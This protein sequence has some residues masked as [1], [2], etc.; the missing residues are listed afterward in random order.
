MK[1][2]K[3]SPKAFRAWRGAR[4]M[5]FALPVF[6]A[7]CG[8]DDDKTDPDDGPRP[9]NTGAAC[10]APDDCYPNVEASDIQGEVRCLDRV[11]D[12]YCTHLCEADDN[13]CAAEGECKEGI[14]QV[15]SPFE[16]TD[17]KMCFLSCEEAD[18]KGTGDAEDANAYCQQ[19][20][21]TEFICRSSGGGSD[22]RKV[23]VP[24]NCGLGAAC[25]VDADC[26]A[27][28]TCLLE[29]GGGYCGVKGCTGNADCPEGSA[30]VTH[31]NDEN[32]CFATCERDAD[33]T[34]CRWDGTKPGCTADVDFVDPGD[35][36]VCPPSPK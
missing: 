36:R 20:A 15:C 6:I 18:L 7:A 24:G 33:C 9:E 31:T 3:T 13:C 8:S 26:G 17:E 29:F 2:A 5:C 16:S 25:E 23:C 22:N 1:T 27:D 28:L 12:G 30:C 32:Y 4:S 19:E 14:S 34:F 35:L 21:G 10:E 11:K